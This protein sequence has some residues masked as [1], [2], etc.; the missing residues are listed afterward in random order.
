MLKCPFFFGIGFKDW[1]NK[2]AK[3]IFIVLVFIFVGV[4][5]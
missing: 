1:K 3:T 2:K 5:D 4:L